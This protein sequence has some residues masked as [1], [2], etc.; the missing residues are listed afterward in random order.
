MSKFPLVG[1]T[2]ITR[3]EGLGSEFPLASITVSEAAYSPG[4]LNLMFPGLLAVDVGVEPPGKIH[5]YFEAV[6]FV[7]KLTFDPAVTVTSPAGVAITPS[8]G[9]VPYCEISMNCAFEGTPEVSRR[10]SM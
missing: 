3:T 9:V 7:V 2:W 1:M 4:V 5:E 10:K 8:G 6:V